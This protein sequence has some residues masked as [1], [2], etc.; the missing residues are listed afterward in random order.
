MIQYGYGYVPYKS[1]VYFCIS[2]TSYARVI[3]VLCNP[4]GYAFDNIYSVENSYFVVGARTAAG[5]AYNA[6]I[7]W[8]A[9][10]F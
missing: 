9:C 10:G 4:D 3:P 6:Y 7:M 8:I 1:A 2:F 5:S